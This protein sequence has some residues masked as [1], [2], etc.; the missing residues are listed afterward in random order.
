MSHFQVTVSVVRNRNKIIDGIMVY[1][2]RPVSVRSSLSA[3][4][5]IA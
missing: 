4:K 5:N 1:I 2:L 3:Q